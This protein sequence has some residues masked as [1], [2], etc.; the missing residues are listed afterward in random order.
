MQCMLTA[1]V[2][3]AFADTFRSYWFPADIVAT[4]MSEAT[5]NTLDLIDPSNDIY[6]VDTLFGGIDQY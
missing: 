5:A 2:S 3:N 6:I 4:K 1:A